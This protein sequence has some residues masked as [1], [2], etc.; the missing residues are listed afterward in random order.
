MKIYFKVER[1]IKGYD[2]NVLWSKLTDIASIPN[3]WHGHRE[4]EIMESDGNK[5]RAKI[6]Y[7][8]P[9][10]G[11]I[12]VGESIIR[13]DQENKVL[14]FD[15]YKGPIK[16]IIKIWIDEKENKI[17]CTYD[18]AMSSLYLP[19]KSWIVQHFK[20]GVEHA[21]DRLLDS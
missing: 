5:H 14:S 9:A 3:Y 16:G 19:V 6:V 7:A 15:N 10:I 4:V 12:N 11:K 17:S 13:T 20:Q 2:P 18:V 21:F 1:D 8:F